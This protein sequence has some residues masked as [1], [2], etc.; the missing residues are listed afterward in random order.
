LTAICA[1]KNR[2]KKMMNAKYFD[3]INEGG[4]GYRPTTAQDS[5]TTDEKIFWL[6]S[7]L[8]DAE[9]EGLNYKAKKIREQILALKAKNI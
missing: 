8:A 4:D 6:L 1:G 7:D 2:G 5:R 9:T 3:L